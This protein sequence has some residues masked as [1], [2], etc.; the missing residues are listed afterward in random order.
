MGEVGESMGAAAGVNGGAFDDRAGV[1]AGI[2][3][4]CH[5]LVGENIGAS[6]DS[7]SCCA[8]LLR[9]IIKLSMLW[10]AGM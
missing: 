10:C 6:G 5:P 9:S 7:A 2:F 1:G 4:A 3:W 8:L